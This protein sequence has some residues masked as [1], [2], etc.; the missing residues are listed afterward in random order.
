MI[1]ILKTGV[2]DLLHVGHVRALEKCKALGDILIVGVQSDATVHE[3]KGREPVLRHE[4]RME[5]VRSLSCVDE[6][7]LISNLNYAGLLHKHQI[8]IFA[9][10]ESCPMEHRHKEALDYADASG[11]A[12]VR[13]PYTD[14]IFTIKIKEKINAKR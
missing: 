6:V 1:R 3:T 9:L 2:W 13:I 7:F 12:V 4:D 5:M 8:D 11:I 10:E 14:R